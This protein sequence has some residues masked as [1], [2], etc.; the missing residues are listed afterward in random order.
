[1]HFLSLRNFKLL[2]SLI[3][4]FS[5]SCETEKTQRK[6]GQMEFEENV[7]ILNKAIVLSW[8]EY[9]GMDEPYDGHHVILGLYSPEAE[10][11]LNDDMEVDSIAGT[12]HG[13][14]F[15]LFAE[16][17]QDIELQDFILSGDHK[18]GTY[19]FGLVYI[20]FPFSTG[21]MWDGKVVE[22]GLLTISVTDE[23]LKVAGS[24]SL[25]TG[26]KLQIDYEGEYLFLQPPQEE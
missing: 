20:D 2:I 1:M 10:I 17:P 8:G 18:T 23:S 7:Y 25:N 14:Q 16:N 22:D 4:I 24:F 5:F 9:N 19:T 26:E 12:G 13:V 21:S 6:I 3:F 11:I 15:E